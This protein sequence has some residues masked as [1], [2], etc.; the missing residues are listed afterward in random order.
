LDTNVLLSLLWPPH[1]F[2][3]TAAEWFLAH[4][5]QGWATCTLTELGFLR[6]VTNPTFTPHP[7]NLANAISLM[8]A[9]KQAGPHH[10]FWKDDLPAELSIGSFIPRISGHKRLTDAY[11]LSLAVHH[12]A[13][14]ATFDL[15][16]PGVTLEGSAERAVIEVLR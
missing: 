10:R 11:L 7:P 4:Q 12:H 1:D 13:R 15:R 8:L 16:V 6:I 2:H 3:A 9:A 14:F 5:D